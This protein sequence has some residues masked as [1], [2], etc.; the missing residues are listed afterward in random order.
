METQKTEITQLNF[1]LGSKCDMITIPTPFLFSFSLIVVLAWAFASKHWGFGL[2]PYITLVILALQSILIGVRWTYSYTDG[3]L[4]QATLAALI[5]PLV[6]SSLMKLVSSNTS[7]QPL[8]RIILHCLPA[9]VVLL[10]P[11]L[12]LREIDALII[13]VFVGYGI[14]LLYIGIKPDLEWRDRVP[15]RST[16]Q[17]NFAFLITGV[18]LLLSAFVDIAIS[19]DIRQNGGTLA[20]QIVGIASST[21]VV[22]LAIAIVFVGH[23]TAPLHRAEESA[24]AP[25]ADPDG[26]KP[27]SQQ[28]NQHLMQRTLEEMDRALIERKLYRDPDISLDR[29][30]R[31]LV[32]PS[33]QI[34]TSVNS[35][36]AMN[37]SQYINLFR[38]TEA[39][40]LLRNSDCSITDVMFDVGFNTKS[41]FN[42]EFRRIVG[43]SPR[44]WCRRP[45]VTEENFITDLS[46]NLQR[47]AAQ[48]GK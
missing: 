47:G 39:A 1:R 46:I 37:V 20:P 10:S 40:H 45:E 48:D 19:Y 12:H 44:E 7:R 17:T 30:S 43:M 9:L 21:L 29:L 3:L 13:A 28:E 34:S 32:I 18:C 4:V 14:A 5:P 27:L 16:V 8:E 25:V 24:L 26:E 42:R 41:N 23:Y 15:F 35:L 2:L 6:F 22:S 36:R 38:I 33:R 11:F 31:K